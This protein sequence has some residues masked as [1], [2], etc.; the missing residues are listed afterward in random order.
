MLVIL[1]N[2]GMAIL[3]MRS[4]GGFF[5]N[6]FWTDTDP[7][8]KDIFIYDELGFGVGYF[9]DLGLS[10][11]L[12]DQNEFDQERYVNFNR[13]YGTLESQDGQKGLHLRGGF[14]EGAL[15]QAEGLGCPNVVGLITIDCLSIWNDAASEVMGRTSQIYNW[16]E[17]NRE[18][19]PQAEGTVVGP[20]GGTYY[21]VTISTAPIEVNAAIE[22]TFL[23]VLQATIAHELGHGINIPHHGQESTILK[24]NPELRNYLENYSSNDIALLYWEGAT[25]LPG[26]IWSGDVRCVMRYTP[27][28]NYLGWDN[29]I[30]LYPEDEGAASRTIYCSSK[31]GTGINSPPRRWENGRPYPVAG[32]ATKGECRKMVDLKGAHYG[33]N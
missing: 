7:T 6:G 26:G 17:I 31:E 3:I 13:G 11:H 1:K 21:D 24:N 12:I 14:V 22:K 4:T 23:Q 25:A 32:E 8:Y 28:L 27:P 16:K 2:Q 30:Y 9:T 5:V 20:L 15:G 10:I 18:D 33:G 29:K 19:I